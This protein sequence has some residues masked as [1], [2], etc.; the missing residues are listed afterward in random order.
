M[1]VAFADILA[2]KRRIGPHVLRT[3]LG[4]SI[5]LSET[6][7]FP[8]FF[9]FEHQ[10]ITGSF[11]LRGA[12]NAVLAMPPEALAKGVC[13]ASTGNHGRA[14]AHAAKAAGSRAIICMSRLVPAN[15][16]RAIE[17]L[18]AEAR[19]VGKS[20]DEAQI[21][22]DRLVGEEGLAGIP[23]FD[24]GDVIA[25]Q[26]TLGLEII[27]DHPDLDAVLVPLSG[28]GLIAGV[29]LAIKT[30]SPKTRVIG[31]TMERGAAMAACLAAGK[32]IDVEE[33]ET[34]AD[35]LGG[36]IGLNNRFTFE[37]AQRLVDDTI[38][39]SEREIAE[40]IRF[41]YERENEVLE[42]AAAVG[43]AAILSGRFAAKGPTA[44]V[45]SGKNIDPATHLE[46]VSGRHKAFGD[47]NG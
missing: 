29:A 44:L 41:A 23:P 26:G 37:I 21:E 15:K 25:G 27:E 19:I 12:T 16:V 38:L 47:H 9:K 6:A 18:G 17:A 31:V 2:A 3:R 28:G 30:A 5:A 13:A 39:V 36:G 4:Q 20:Q 7:G 33:V 22:V 14:L 43:I 1:G 46:I 8:V 10:Q 24:H 11:K 45:L 34:L 40:A 32:P 42:G 35:S